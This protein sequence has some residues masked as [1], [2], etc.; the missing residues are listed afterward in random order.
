MNKKMH[1]FMTFIA[2]FFLGVII[3]KPS[4]AFYPE[5]VLKE[6]KWVKG[7]RI[8]EQINPDY[9]LNYPVIQYQY[10]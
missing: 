10:K 7:R 8:C 2:L 5:K 3:G 6:C 9:S 4:S 1:F